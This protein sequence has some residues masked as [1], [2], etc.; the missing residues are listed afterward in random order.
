MSATGPGGD[1]TACPGAVFL[2]ATPPSN[3]G[4]RTIEWEQAN[5]P[6][7]RNDVGIGFRFLALQIGRG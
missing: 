3:E 6:E 1:P 5:C 4:A 2:M 7:T